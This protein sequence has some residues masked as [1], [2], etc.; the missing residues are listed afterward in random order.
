MANGDAP[1][2]ELSESGLSAP[3]LT[4]SSNKVEDDELENSFDVFLFDVF[5]GERAELPPQ[6]RGRVF[7]V[8]DDQLFIVD[9]GSPPPVPPT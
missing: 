4:E 2:I 9:P 6:F 3:I 8:I 5:L 1:R 7:R